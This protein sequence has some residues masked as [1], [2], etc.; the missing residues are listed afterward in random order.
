MAVASYH[1]LQDGAPVIRAVDL[2]VAQQRPLQ[3]AKL[4]E[5]EKRVIAGAA[6]V[7]VVGRALL[8]A[9]GWTD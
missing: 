5:A 9:V 1:R 3:I 7:A 8:L 2:A 6:E 4:V